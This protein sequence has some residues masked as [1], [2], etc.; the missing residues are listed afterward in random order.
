MGCDIHCYKEKFVNGKWIST[1]IWE[2]EDGYKR[3]PYE[4]TFSDRNYNLFGLL[5]KGVRFEH[6]YSLEPR[7]MPFDPSEEV[8][9]AYSDWDSDGHSHSYLYLHELKQFK[10]FLE[11]KTINVSGLMNKE[12][13][14]SLVKSIEGGN[15]NWDLI[16]PYCQASSRSDLIEFSLDPPAIYMVGEGLNKIISIF[17]EAEE[18]QRLVFWFDN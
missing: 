11:S 1:D 3:V 4:S 8:F 6:Q 16:Y 18:L 13:H 9:M 15:P 5:S 7:G 2:Q 14:E 12:Q 10:A 17:D